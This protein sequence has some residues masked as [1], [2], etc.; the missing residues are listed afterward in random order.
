M[1]PCGSDSKAVPPDIRVITMS[2]FGYDAE[3]LVWLTRKK[4]AKKIV[5]ELPCL[6]TS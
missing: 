6:K 2:S 4:N 1:V 5:N 3:N